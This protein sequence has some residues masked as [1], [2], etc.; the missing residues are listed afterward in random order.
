[1]EIQ[2]LGDASVKIQD[3]EDARRELIALSG[4][5]AP[6]L[7][8][9]DVVELQSQLVHVNLSFATEIADI[10]ESVTKEL[11]R[12]IDHMAQELDFQIK[13]SDYISVSMIPPVVLMLQLI[14]MTA[15]SANNIIGVF[16]SLQ[17]PIDPISFLKK[18]IPLIF[19][20]GM[21]KTK[22][23]DGTTSFSTSGKNLKTKKEFLL[24]GIIYMKI[25]F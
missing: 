13:P 15:G 11:N 25:L 7:G 22:K 23:S 24:F 20:S 4:V 1:M 10:Q 19:L 16:Q 5:P 3:L 17:L 9:G 14:E 2:S 6:Y 8:Y 12:M 21:R 18:Y